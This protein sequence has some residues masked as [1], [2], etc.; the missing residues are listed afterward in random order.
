M[1]TSTART[2]LR[3]ARPLLRRAVHR[4]VGGR[5]IEQP[6]DDVAAAASMP[7]RN[8]VTIDFSTASGTRPTDLQV[9]QRPQTFAA[10]SLALLSRVQYPSAREQSDR[11]LTR[12]RAP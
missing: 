10:R 2:V 1:K 8:Y 3:L 5:R 4:R 7:N 11:V 12:R 6:D 9:G